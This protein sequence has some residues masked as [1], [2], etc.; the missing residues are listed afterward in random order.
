MK[1]RIFAFVLAA[2][3]VMCLFSG[4]KKAGKMDAQ[5]ELISENIETWAMS[6]ENDSATYSYGITDLDQN[7]R[8][9]VIT[10]KMYGKMSAVTEITCYEVSKDKKSLEKCD[11]AKA[12]DTQVDIE[13]ETAQ[14][15]EVD[16]QFYYVFEDRTYDSAS[17][18]YY[19]KVAITLQDGK[20]TEEVLAK[21]AKLAVAIDDE[22]Y[23]ETV[24]YT[25]AQGNTITE[26]QYEN[27]G[28]DRFDGTDKTIAAFGWFGYSSTNHSDLMLYSTEKR[29]EILKDSYL[30]FTVDREF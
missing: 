19:A 29:N 17:A 6:T 16:D 15:F 14:C 9:E 11:Y 21:K 13:A 25:D 3:L 5:I 30:K 23:E 18:D 27:A 24:T 2:V 20:I 4:C 26:A 7:G 28:V 10:F 12:G 8:L 1:K 22:N